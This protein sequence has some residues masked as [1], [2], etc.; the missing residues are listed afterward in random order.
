MKPSSTKPAVW[1]L[2]VTAAIVTT[3]PLVA[4]FGVYAFHKPG[5]VVDLQWFL[6][7]MMLVSVLF[8]APLFG[9][10][11][12]ARV[13]GSRSFTAALFLAALAMFLPASILAFHLSPLPARDLVHNVALAVSMAGCT[14]LLYRIAFHLVSLSPKLA[15]HARRVIWAAALVGWLV[16]FLRLIVIPDTFEGP[17]V[18]FRPVAQA[19]LGA[20]PASGPAYALALIVVALYGVHRQISRRYP[21]AG[22]P[23]AQS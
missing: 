21:V 9:A 1:K 16:P 19:L 22:K 2:I 15:P 10:W 6:G 4:M 8:A 7:D 23:I 13:P 12:R 20:R 17:Y 14:S 5:A 11:G 18:I 3:F